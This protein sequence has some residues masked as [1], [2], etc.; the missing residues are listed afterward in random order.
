MANRLVAPLPLFEKRAM[1][2][3]RVISIAVLLPILIALMAL[4][5]YVW[6]VAVVVVAFLGGREF[7]QL[8]TRCGHRPMVPL[9]L[10]LTGLL[11]LEGFWPT[12]MGLRLILVGGLMASLVWALLQDSDRG[13][14]DWAVTIA[15][16]VFLGALL[17]HF[18][19]LRQLTSGLWWL[20]LALAT[21]WMGDGGAYLVGLT[22]GHRKLWP[23]IS[24]NKTVEGTLGGF[25]FAVLGALAALAVCRKW[26]PE[27]AVAQ[28]SWA[29]AALVGAILGPF[30]LAGDL[31]ISMFKRRAAMKDSGTLIPGHGGM[32]DR[33]DSLLFTVPLVYYWA[34]LLA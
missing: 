25:V 1:L 19:A 33:L 31:V 12:P 27:T 24:P 29:S 21:V 15:G 2:R 4:G 17:A 20:V 34:L 8:M 18:V 16:A 7:C 13:V 6:L 14:A 32:L 30:A 3:T 5:G 9:A 28:V 26:A 22:F 11:V 10:A 23:K